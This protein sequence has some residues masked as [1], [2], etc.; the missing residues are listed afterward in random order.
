MA[1][2]KSGHPFLP[3]ARTRGQD[4][5]GDR[6]AIVDRSY[7]RRRPGSALGLFPLR[8]R[9]YCSLKNDFA[10]LRLN[11]DLLCVSRGA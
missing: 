3:E 10:P 11:G 2:M 5:Y 8:P 6:D 7:P 1:L 4:L 9:A